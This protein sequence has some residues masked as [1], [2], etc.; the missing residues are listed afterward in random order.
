MRLRGYVRSAWLGGAVF[1]VPVGWF[2]ADQ[3]WVALMTT[4]GMFVLLRGAIWIGMQNGR[5][6]S[7]SVTNSTVGGNVTQVRGVRGGYRSHR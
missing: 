2:I 4:I 7:Q 1:G 3:Y 6:S 5:M